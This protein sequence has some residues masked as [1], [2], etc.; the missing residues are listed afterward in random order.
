VQ[1]LNSKF[2]SLKDYITDLTSKNLNIEIIALQEIWQVNHLDLVTIPGF[3]PLISTQ[4]R[5]MR[6]GGV[7]F[8][9]KDTI[10][11]QF[12]PTL[13]PFENKIIESITLLL[14]HPNKSKFFVT[15]LYKSNGIIPNITI[16][17]QNTRFFDLFETLLEN[18]AQKQHKS[19]IFTDSNINLLEINPL[20]MQY[21]NTILTNGFLQLQTKATRIVGNSRTLL[22]HIITNVTNNSFCTGTLI[23][24]ISD[25][26]PIFIFNGKITELL[27]KLMSWPEISHCPT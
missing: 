26:F 2:D 16:N 1:S 18:L 27:N 19:L 17:D 5:G 12:I 24:D 7:G 21:L 10:S 25:H 14:S 3:H 4:R 6:G 20:S 13:S 9:I 23:C 11:Y 15:S 22:D 8:Y